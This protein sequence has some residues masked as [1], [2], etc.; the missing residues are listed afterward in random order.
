MMEI[1][2]IEVEAAALE[3]RL[4]CGGMRVLWLG[5]SWLIHPDLVR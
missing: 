1:E 4:R 2:C 3:S 5:L